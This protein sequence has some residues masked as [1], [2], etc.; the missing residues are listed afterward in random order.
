MD[1]EEFQVRNIPL[2]RQDKVTRHPQH[3]EIGVRFRSL[4]KRYR[5][6]G[7]KVVFRPEQRQHDSR[8]RLLRTE[9][10]EVV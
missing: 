9:P 6:L 1:R 5:C 7:S 3:L 2:I 4:D 8:S 10:K